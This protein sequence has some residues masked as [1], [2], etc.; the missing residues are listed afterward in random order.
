MIG[1]RSAAL[2]HVKLKIN[3]Q[4]SATEARR[5]SIKHECIFYSFS[6]D[7]AFCCE[8]LRMYTATLLFLYLLA[9]AK[10]RQP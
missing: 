3:G 5:A 9:R 7:G 6:A 10:L 4:L 2:R 8:N 1:H